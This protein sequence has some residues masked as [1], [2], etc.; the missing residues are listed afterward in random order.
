MLPTAIWHWSWG[1]RIDPCS[2]VSRWQT[3]VCWRH[4]LSKASSCL[5][6]SSSN[7]FLLT[8][9]F[10]CPALLPQHPCLLSFSSGE[11]NP[12]TY[13]YT[14]IRAHSAHTNPTF[15]PVIGSTHRVSFSIS[16]QQLEKLEKPVSPKA[17]VDLHLSKYKHTFHQAINKL[18]GLGS[19]DH[20]C[21]TWLKHCRGTITFALLLFY[22]VVTIILLYL[23]GLYLH[24]IE[25][26]NTDISAFNI[27]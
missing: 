19:L 18:F 6:F 20:R 11:W 5:G 4:Y 27:S 13:T 15:L 2:G 3:R 7:Y 17:F 23:L 14:Q 10:G 1:T 26:P 22:R 21:E 8:L 24:Y 12:C 25:S 9:P 16:S